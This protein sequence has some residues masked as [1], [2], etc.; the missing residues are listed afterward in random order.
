MFLLWANTDTFD[1][2]DFVVR[3]DGRFWSFDWETVCRV[4]MEGGFYAIKSA[5][6]VVV[7]FVETATQEEV[8][9]LTIWSAH[10]DS[11]SGSLST[12]SLRFAL[13]FY[14]SFIQHN[15]L[16]S[17][18]GRTLHLLKHL[19]H[20][21]HIHRISLVYSNHGWAESFYVNLRF[22]FAHARPVLIGHRPLCF[23]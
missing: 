21:L 10:V 14:A 18:L 23:R 16:C 15:N 2:S 17:R 12:S 8:V 9:F 13:F 19:I 7:V 1:S 5:F 22:I 11:F 4:F 6:V 20:H 3:R